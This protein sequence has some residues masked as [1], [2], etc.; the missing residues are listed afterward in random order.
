MAGNKDR[1]DEVAEKM[2]PWI[3]LPSIN[4]TDVA[5]ADGTKKLERGVHIKPLGEGDYDASLLLDALKSVEYGG[6]VILHN[7]G[8]A[9][10]PVDHVRTSFA[11]FQEMVE[12]L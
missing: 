2:K 8:L 1:L 6:P 4:G 7:W 10:A 11:R 12:K 5:L 9:D 3:R